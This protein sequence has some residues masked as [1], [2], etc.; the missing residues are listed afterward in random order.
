[1]E[2][3]ELGI[4]SKSPARLRNWRLK[5]QKREE[6]EQRKI[7][8]WMMKYE[9]RYFQCVI[10]IAH[11]KR[12]FEATNGKLKKGTESNEKL[13]RVRRMLEEEEGAVNQH[14]RMYL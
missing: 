2:K 10:Q 4:T 12:R 6:Q 9:V 14:Y 13:G 5:E 8:I 11:G 1:M 3:A 7:P